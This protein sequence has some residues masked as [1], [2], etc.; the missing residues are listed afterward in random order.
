MA[1]SDE[2]EAAKKVVEDDESTT[3]TTLAMVKKGK[4]CIA[5]AETIYSD[6]TKGCVDN[7]EQKLKGLEGDAEE[8]VKHARDRVKEAGKVEEQYKQE[9]RDIQRKIGELELQKEE[10][11][12]C[13]PGLEATLRF[14]QQFQEQVSNDLSSAESRLRDAKYE[15]GRAQRQ[16]TNRVGGGATIGA[17]IG[18]LILP[19]M[20][21]VIGAA[22]GAG[23]GLAVNDSEVKEAQN[24]VDDCR[25]RYNDAQAEVSK[26]NSAVSD[27][28]SQ[29]QSVTSQCQTLERQCEQYNEKAKKMKEALM[30]FLEALKFWKKFQDIS[31]HGANCTAQLQRIISIAKAE[32]KEED[33]KWLNGK[34]FLDAWVMIETKCEQGVDFIF[35]IEQ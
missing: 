30:L 14:K 1:T 18:T 24:R 26:A 20:G 35:Q 11:K 7:V 28:Q 22:A 3:P 32:N 12:Q 21:T 23:A 19:G 2:S 13:K 31:K 8:L 34:S 15:L 5:M 25:R 10:L 33:L 27:I 9:S 6:L 17:L 4:D 16:Q 29:I